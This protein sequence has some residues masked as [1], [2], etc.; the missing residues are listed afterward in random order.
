MVNWLKVAGIALIVIGVILVLGSP[1]VIYTAE[2]G[3][4]VIDVL[5]YYVVTAVGIA[6]IVVGVLLYY[7]G[8]RKEKKGA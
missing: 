6:L 5:G 1:V 2:S 4:V 8:R 7:L 3:Q